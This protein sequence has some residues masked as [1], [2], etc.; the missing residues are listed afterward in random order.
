MFS[1]FSPIFFTTTTSTTQ[2]ITRPNLVSCR[3]E[4]SQEEEIIFYAFGTM[5]SSTHC[6]PHIDDDRQLPIN[7]GDD[8]DFMAE[9]QYQQYNLD[10]DIE[11]IHI[12]DDDDEDVDKEGEPKGRFTRCAK[13]KPAID[14]QT[15]GSFGES[16]VLCLRKQ[17][18]G[19][20]T[21][22]EYFF[23]NQC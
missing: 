6:S 15:R 21:K 4:Y 22:G 8:N 1:Q 2:S 5:R 3:Y 11:D 19:K 17:E 18:G 14:K 10:D 12:Q 9:T 20:S 7:E 23:G 13:S 16:M